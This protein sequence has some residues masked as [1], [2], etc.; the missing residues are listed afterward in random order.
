M[1]KQSW[2]IVVVHPPNYPWSSGF[3]PVVDALLYGLRTLGNEVTWAENNFSSEATNI[4]LGAHLLAEDSWPILD[5]VPSVIYNLEPLPDHL[6]YW[7][8][9]AAI[10]GQRLVWD[11][12]AENLPWHAQRGVRA[13]HVPLGHVPIWERVKR[14]G[15]P[16]IDVLFVGSR[17]PRRDAILQ[18]LMDRGLR[19]GVVTN[20][21]GSDLD[22]VIARARVVLNC[23]QYRADAPPEWPRLLYL[24]ANRCAVVSEGD[25]TQLDSVWRDAAWW[26]P[27][28]SLVDACVAMVASPT[29]QSRLQMDG[30]AAV[31]QR[32]FVDG[33]RIALTLPL[34]R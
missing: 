18:A 23:H 4:I 33:L 3:F 21:Y 17:T 29:S 28:D 25:R 13:I 11:Y 7:P 9:Y 15:I 22:P 6:S 26:A 10:L 27:Y 30:Y 14:S 1:D 20:A 19:T 16:D 2:H 32:P 8:Q 31:R 24:W 34:P 12:T 5:Q